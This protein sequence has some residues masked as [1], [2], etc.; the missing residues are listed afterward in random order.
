MSHPTT[1]ASGTATWLDRPGG[2]GH[3]G[4][5]FFRRFRSVLI[6][7]DSQLAEVAR[8][9]LLN[10]VRAHL[11]NRA[12]DWPWSSYRA[13]IGK[14]PTPAF[15]SSDWL[16]TEFGVGIEQARVNFAAFIRAAE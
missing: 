2:H 15:L 11:C 14:E 13:M 7:T 6:R 10:P 9:I 1:R 5:A 8:Y 3:K 16:L 4:H 12:E